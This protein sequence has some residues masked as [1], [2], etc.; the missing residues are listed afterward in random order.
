MTSVRLQC[1]KDLAIGELGLIVKG[2]VLYDFPMAT[3]AGFGIAHDLIEHQNGVHNIKSIGDELEAIGGIW[4]ARGQWGDIRRDS[5]GGYYSP[6]ESISQ[7]VYTLAAL[8][9]TRVKSFNWPQHKTRPHRW[10]DSFYSI[11][12]IAKP[13]ILEQIESGD[14]KSYRIE[15]ELMRERYISRMNTFFNDAIHYM[16]TGVRKAEKRFG[17]GPKANTLFWNIAEAVEPFAK[18]CEYEGQEYIL[19]YNWNEAKCR[20]VYESGY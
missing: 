19:T 15:T 9:I 11:L 2:T 1:V 16:R 5:Y 13:K 7:D 14:L 6:E 4:H 10:D 8:Y 18:H 17:E 20:E 12:E 3:Y